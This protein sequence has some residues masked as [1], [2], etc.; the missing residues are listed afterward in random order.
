MTTK[1]LITRRSIEM[2]FALKT[3]SAI[4]IQSKKQNNC[5]W[6]DDRFYKIEFQTIFNGQKSYKKLIN[7]YLIAK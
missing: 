7:S 6:H 5:H 3:C 1:V 4:I 2:F